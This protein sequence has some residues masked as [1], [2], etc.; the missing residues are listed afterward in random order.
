MA[1]HFDCPVCHNSIT[2]EDQFGGKRGK[3]NK[4]GELLRIPAPVVT[5]GNEPSEP[6]SPPQ[7]ESGKVISMIC[8][9]CGKRET[10][11]YMENRWQ[12]LSCGGKFLYEKPPIPPSVVVQPTKETVIHTGPTDTKGIENRLDTMSG[13]QANDQQQLICSR[14]G[15]IYLNPTNKDYSDKVEYSCFNCGH[16]VYQPKT[17][18]SAILGMIVI[19]FLLLN[20]IIF[21]M[22][23]K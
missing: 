5:A 23:N 12:C 14:C 11:E 22:A 21:S 6:A 19:M 9:S 4:C 16:L 17:N 13:H 8:P 2:V 3:C 15:S 20:C 7:S 1:I 18:W 10:S